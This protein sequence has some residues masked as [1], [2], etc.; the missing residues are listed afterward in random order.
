[1]MHIVYDDKVLRSEV[2]EAVAFDNEHPIL[3][4]KYVSGQECEVDAVCY[5]EDVCIPGIM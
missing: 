3:V 2:E 4:D 5:G 1:M